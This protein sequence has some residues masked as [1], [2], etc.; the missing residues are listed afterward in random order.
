VCD[1]PDVIYLEDTDGD[2]QA[3]TRKVLLT[4]FETHNEQARVNSFRLGLD[5]WLYGSC[6]I[7][8][9]AI[10][11]FN[12]Q[13]LQLGNR[14]FRFRPDTGEIEP[15]TGRTQQSRVRDEWGNWFGCSSGT[16]C[17]HYPLDDRYL[18]RNP[19]VIPTALERYVPAGDNADRLFP[20]SDLVLFRESGPPGRPTAACG[21]E[22]YRDE[23]LGP[24]FSGNAFVAEPVN[25]LVHRIVLSESG[26]TFAGRRADE[27]LDREF[28]ASTDHWF[29]PVQIRTGLDGG[30]WVVDMCRFVIEHP[31]FIPP[32]TLQT[33]DVRAGNL[34]GRIF[35]VRPQGADVRVPKPVR[36]LDIAS[37]VAELNSPNGPY[38]DLVHERLIELQD[39]NAVPLL[40]RLVEEAERPAT[41]LQALCVLDGMSA[42]GEASALRGL[43]DESPMVRRHALRLSESLLDK[44]TNVAAGVA[45]LSADK[46]PQ[47]QLHLIYA[48]GQTNSAAAGRLLAEL[49]WRHRES[50]D[51]QTAVN[52]GAEQHQY[53]EWVRRCSRVAEANRPASNPQRFEDDVHGGADQIRG[54]SHTA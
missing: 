46:H 22:I 17:Q 9:G 3:D 10:R 51:F 20:I 42:L 25:Q 12:G 26:I 44:S 21:L 28:L 35:R 18:K 11:S 32:E 15:V 5:N 47:V 13:E 27:E 7:F 34:A 50:P 49:A 24:A 19:Y 23:L 37:L 39:R 43:R 54:C 4:G 48:L 36:N 38:R 45:E 33:L 8:G 14:D 40:E 52:S 2:G 53:R 1:A 41:R 29:R 31:R 16:L 6:G 30:L